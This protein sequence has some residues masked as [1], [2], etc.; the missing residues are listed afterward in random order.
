VTADVVALRPDSDKAAIAAAAAERDL[1]RSK[2]SVHTKRAYRRHIRNY[3][4]WLA[5]QSG[6][7]PDA[8]ADAIGAEA[9][10]TAW[11]RELLAAKLAASSVGQAL[12]AVTLLYEHGASMRLKVDRPGVP[13]PRRPWNGPIRARSNGPPAAAAPA[14]GRLSPC[15]STAA[16]ASRSAPRIDTG[17]LA[18]TERTG[19]L[20]LHGKGDKVRSVPVPQEARKVIRTWLDE[21]GREPGPLWLGQ[22]GRLTVSGITQAVLAVGADANVPGLR[23]HR[24][25]HTY[26]TRLRQGGA[27][28]AHIQALLGHASIEAS[29]RYFR[30]GGTG[31]HRRGRLRPTQT[32]SEALRTRPRLRD[33]GMPWRCTRTR[34]TS[35]VFGTT[36]PATGVTDPARGWGIAGTGTLAMP[37]AVARDAVAPESP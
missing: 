9:A 36:V 16:P 10:V 19:T 25:R 2:L 26:A 33:R 13:A 31:R 8:F 14:T 12:A 34:P 29:A 24:L 7:H 37:R 11:R 18:L 23:P 3:L 1:D 30:P 20:R 28:P 22:R 15:C 21:R 27:D 6:A 35:Q 17:D 4:A 32:L 5:G